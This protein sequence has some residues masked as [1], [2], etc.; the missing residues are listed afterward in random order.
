VKD[1]DIDEET[2]TDRVDELLEICVK[3]AL[4]PTEGEGDAS[5][6]SS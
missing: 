5:A 6:A 3:Q 1:C 2:D 4:P